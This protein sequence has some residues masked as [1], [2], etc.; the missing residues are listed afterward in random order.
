[1]KIKRSHLRNGLILLHLA[2]AILGFYLFTINY[3]LS[4]V[5]LTQ[6]ALVKQAILAKAGSTSI[7]N[8]IKNVQNQL[9]SFVFSFAPG[10]EIV[11]INIAH[12][13]L[14]FDEYIQR[15][16]LPINGVVLYDENG[17]LNILGNRQHI[18]TGEGQ[19]FAQTSYI[20]WSKDPTNKGKTYI[21]TPYIGTTGASIGKT[22]IL[23]AQ[24]IYFGD[25]YKGTLAIKLLVDDFRKSFIDTLASDPAED[26][27]II[28]NKGLLLA[29]NTAL[30][31]Q[32]LFAY[33]QKQ[34]WNQYKDFTQKLSTTIKTN[35]SQAVW[36]F[37][38]PKDKTKVVFV[39]ISKID[40]PNTDN[41]LYIVVNT[42]KDDALA[43]LQPLRLYGF[44]WLGFGLL[45]S[46]LGAII[47]VLL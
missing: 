35:K 4:E 2:F 16:Q 9:S 13:R 41:D 43:S 46:F 14:A 26:S 6:K 27:F 22:I 40:I 8:L 23:V 25:T 17:T 12:T 38:N 3:H 47:A 15:A 33:A 34:K 37:Q 18:R 32:N 29:G 36:T 19:N 11:P 45:A 10:S 39:G 30:I 21:S 1:M 24:P 20:R 5:Q 42:S 7:E 44:A 28:T 31:N